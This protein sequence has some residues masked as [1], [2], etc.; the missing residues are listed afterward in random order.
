MVLEA[1]AFLAASAA[2]GFGITY[3]SGIAFTLEERIV[4]GAVIGAMAVS[5]TTF[6]PALVV[7]DVTMLT[8]LLGLAMCVVAGA[9]GVWLSRSRLAA[10][11]L[12]ARRRWLMPLTS[13]TH[14]WPLLLVF[15]ICGAWTVHLMHQAYVYTADGLY[16]GYV[17]IWGDW[18][19]HLSFAGSFA[20]AHNFPPEFPVDPGHRLGYPFMVDFLAADLI[21]LGMRLTETLTVTS[22]LLG[23]ALPAVLYLAALRFTAGRAAAFIAVFVFLL[24]GGLGFVYLVSDL[25]R[26]GPTVLAHLPHEYTL[27]RE[28]NLQWLNPVLAYLVPQRS[29]LFGFSLTL[30]VLVVLWIAARERMGWRPFLFAGLVAAVMP[31][32]HVHAYGTVI[33]LPAFWILFSRRVEWLAYF[34]P[35]LVI[36]VP[37]LVWMLPPDNTAVCGVE[38]SI[39]IFCIQLG[40]LSP[41]DLLRDGPIVFELEWLLFWLW[42]TSVFLPLLITAHVVLRSLPTA[43]PTWFAPMWLWFAV[44]NLIVLQPWIWDNTKFFVFWLL[45]GSILVGALLAKMLRHSVAAAGLAAAMMVLLGLSGALDLA[46]ASDYSVSAFQFTD[47]G[48]LKVADWVRQNTSPDAIFA[49]ADEHNS[50]IPTLAGRRELIGYP[51]WLWTYGLAD[52]VQKSEDDKSI[53]RGDPSAMDL[54]RRYGVDYVMIGPQE[55]PR[56]AS[57]AYWDEHATQVYDDGEYTV[58]RIDF[59]DG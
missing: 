14:P 9:C 8:V 35:A 54:A 45:L 12:D 4:F 7:R 13:P 2:A 26:L 6:A 33:A 58:Y 44:P 1:I 24:S 41:G 17:N 34:G 27:N 37:I 52:Y 16:A 31:V 39:A 3:L 20:Y 11:W 21:P 48:G 32:F 36:G 53:L 46:R 22:A 47:Q 23:L 56:G 50:P 28:V 59:S 15:A 49:V 10:D 29:T 43:F 55:I 40:W 38:G 51:G 5:V 30:I 18:A 25:Q 19:A 57:R 42:N